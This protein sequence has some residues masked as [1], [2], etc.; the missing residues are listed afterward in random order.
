MHLLKKLGSLFKGSGYVAVK[1]AR[2]FRITD[3]SRWLLT[4]IIALATILI[5]LLIPVVK[6]F[7]AVFEGRDITTA[8]A[9]IYIMQ[10]ITTTGYGE[11]LPFNSIPM[12]ALSIILMVLGV[13]LIF[14]IAGTLMAT[15]IESRITPKAPDS[16]ELTGHV[17]FTRFNNSVQRSIN[18]LEHHRIPYVVAAEEQPEAVELIRRGIN[19]ICASPDKDEGMERLGVNHAQLVIATND[20]TENIS[21]TLGISTKN[22]A[23]VLAVMEN[24]SRA[25]LAYAAGAKRVI[26]VEETLGQQ[27]ADWI[28]ADASPTE[29]LGLMEV[30]VLPEIIQQLKPSILHIGAR[31]EHNHKTIGQARFQTVTGATIAAIW[32][33]DGTITTPTADMQIK[34][35]TLIVLGPHDN[36]DRLASYTGGP[37]AGG[38]VVLVGA[39]RVGQ[40]TGRRLNHA[41]IYP[42]V[43]DISNRPLYFKGNLIV[44]DAVSPHILQQ[45][46][47]DQADTLIV[48]INNDSLNIFI[49]LASRQLNPDI[50]VVARA[51]SSDAVDRLHQAGANHVLSESILG[52]QLLQVAMVELGVLP[53]LSNYVISQITWSNNP[54]RI[55]EL[56]EMYDTAITK[57]VCIVRGSEVMEPRS[58]LLLQ[59]GDQIVVLGSPDQIHK[60]N[61][62]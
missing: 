48:T 2:F 38:R 17:I 5:V 34:E 42:D 51:V 1:E 52:F 49:V 43:I 32:N 45:A 20:D 50:D 44:G 12:M 7:M 60:I 9:A 40:E 30:E 59:K 36:V 14:M 41:G 29:L 58:E 53:R 6:Y 11:L 33:E 62:E 21:I 23:A 61:K 47:I 15:L 46:K 24:E 25:E 56:K 35:S 19:C 4:R 55:Q 3:Y 28:C 37:G 8:Q 54:I 13:I 26:A 31:S 16:T 18:L 57:I 27:L 22:G 39:G 10:T